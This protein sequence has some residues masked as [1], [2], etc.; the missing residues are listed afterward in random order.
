MVRL[1]FW[2]NSSLAP[3]SAKPSIPTCDKL[4]SSCSG[5]NFGLESIRETFLLQKSQESVCSPRTISD[6]GDWCFLKL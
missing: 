6:V 1:I 5:H 4:S 2:T 3:I